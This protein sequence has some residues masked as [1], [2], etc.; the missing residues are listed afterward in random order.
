MSI[1]N[2]YIQVDLKCSNDFI[3]NNFPETSIVKFLGKDQN[4]KHHLRC[5]TFVSFNG[6]KNW[7]MC[8]LDIENLTIFHGS[9][10]LFGKDGF[11]GQ[12]MYSIDLGINWY[13]EKIIL[14]TIIDIIPIETP[15]TQR[16]A[17]IDYNAD[18][19]IYTFFIFDY[20]NAISNF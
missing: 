8:Y 2:C 13:N 12:I 11:T 7:N 6:G 10:L 17:V 15:N 1:K 18:E 5:D 4:W 9:D 20:S 19:M 14:N 3:K 16:F